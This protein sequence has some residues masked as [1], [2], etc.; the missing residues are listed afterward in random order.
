[1]NIRSLFPR[2]VIIQITIAIVAVAIT[3]LTV[4]KVGSLLETK[5]QLEVD[6][7][8]KKETVQ[9]LESEIEYATKN[10][11][12]LEEKL[13]TTQQLS[14]SILQGCLIDDG[15]STITPLYSDRQ[16]YVV[17]LGSYKNIEKAI[18]AIK[19]FRQSDLGKVKLYFAVNDYYAAV[20]G[21]FDEKQAA[22]VALKDARKVVRDAY[23]YNS[24]AF[25]YEIKLQLPLKSSCTG[26]SDCAG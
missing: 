5:E 26:K 23:I 21:I 25:P 12:D 1:V 7:E 8:S 18:S 4:L 9:K 20:L 11:K 16:G 19:K 24:L 10:L 13:R 2:F 22:E 14:E 3:I 6:I 15:L 17:V